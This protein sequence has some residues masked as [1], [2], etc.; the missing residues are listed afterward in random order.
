MVTSSNPRPIP[1]KNRHASMP[2]AECCSAIPKLVTEYQSIENVKTVRRPNL[3]AKAPSTAEP[4][5]SPAKVAAAK[6][7]WSV[8]PQ[9]P[10]ESSWK[11][12]L[13]I[14]PGLRVAATVLFQIAHDVP[15]AG[16]PFMLQVDAQASPLARRRL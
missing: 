5:K 3:S 10:R 16:N 2:T 4:T 8:S 6:L 12:P 14:R 15:T 7:A 13:R 1:V 11:I 9:S